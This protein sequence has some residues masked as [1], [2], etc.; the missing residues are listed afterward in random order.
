LFVLALLLV[1]IG[2]SKGTWPG[3]P[4]QHAHVVR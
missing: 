2:R 4:P 1:L 3:R